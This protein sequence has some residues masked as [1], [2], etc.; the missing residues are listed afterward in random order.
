MIKLLSTI[1]SNKFLIGMIF[2][3]ITDY[4][5]KNP[6]KSLLLSSS[7]IIVV[8]AA[9]MFCMIEPFETK[10]YNKKYIT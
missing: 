9:G 6:I 10:H 2:Y 3:F 8:S 1:L 5:I 7:F 4:Y